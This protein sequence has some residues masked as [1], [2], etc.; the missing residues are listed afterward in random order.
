M[1]V[2]ASVGVDDFGQ[3]TSR[4]CVCM[5]HGMVRLVGFEMVSVSIRTCRRSGGHGSASEGGW[6]TELGGLL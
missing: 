3:R 5:D 4:R 1:C 2:L 6:K